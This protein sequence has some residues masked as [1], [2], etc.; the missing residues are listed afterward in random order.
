MFWPHAK[1]SVVFSEHQN[2][3]INHA[4]LEEIDAKRKIIM[5][6]TYIIHRLG[7]YDYDAALSS[8]FNDLW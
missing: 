6:F 8:F 4:H 3:L 5:E 7:L 2:S 1:T